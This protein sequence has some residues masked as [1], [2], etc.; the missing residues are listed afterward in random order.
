MNEFDGEDERPFAHMFYFQL[1]DTTNEA[2]NVF[3]KAC[4]DYLGGHPGQIHFSVGVRALHIRRRVSALNFEISVNM[5]FENESAYDVYKFD[6]KHQVF[7]DEVGTMSV[8]RVVYDSYIVH[9]D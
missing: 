7:I 2:K 6:P 5:I 4:I 1:T 9:S 3:I 8:D